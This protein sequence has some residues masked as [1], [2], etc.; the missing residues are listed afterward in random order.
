MF[1]ILILLVVLLIYGVAYVLYGKKLLERRVVKADSKRLTPAYEKFDGVDYVPANKYV[2]YG[3]HFA[4]I[5]GA[6]PIIGPAVAL[7]WGWLL[8]LVWVLFGN[9]FIGAVHDYTAIMASVRHGGVSIMTVSESVMGRRARYIFLAYVWFALVLVLA[10]FL[11]VASSV[12]A[13]VPTAATVA[14][15]YMPLALLFGILVY[16]VGVDVRL[17]TLVSLVLVVAGIVYSFYAPTYLTYEG[18]IVVLALYSIIAAAL[19]VWY[20]L[21]P[22]D[23]L[24]AYL[25]WAFVILAVIAPLLLPVIRFTGPPVITFVAKG[26]VIGAPAGTAA[27]GLDIAW[28]WPTVPLAIACGALSGFHSVVG[29]GTTSKQ[30]ASE[31]DAL[32]VGYGGMLTEGAVSS[33]AVILPAALIWDFAAVAQSAGL[34]ADLLL[35]AGLNVTATPNILRFAGAARFYTAYGFAQALA[36]SRLTG[37][38]LFPQLFAGFKTFAAWALT[39]FVL[40]TLDTS[41]RLARF[42]WV[43]MFDWL[44]PRAPV[45][46][47]VVTN[48]WFASIIPVII[49]AMMAYPTIPGVGRAYLVIWPAFAGT[50]QLLAALAL[51][52]STLWVY[53]IL[54]VRGAPNLLM[55][56]PAMFL[57]ITVTLALIIWLVFIV[58]SLPPLYIAG[59]GTIVTISVILDFLLIALFVRGLKAARGL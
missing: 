31:L 12:Y 2:L 47:K 28:F 24:N 44:K 10:A 11:S 38:E 29:S 41:N 42:A 1:P 13:D 37:V 27:A 56:I 25:L 21:Q 52:T 22:R 34:P 6:G 15:M 58:P 4:S 49:G 14:I 40:T 39:A 36:W 18:W 46:H 20:L 7:A 54:K 51:L 17:A 19:P 23:Y 53:A 5:A 9:I 3:H 32:F 50:N 48:R 43:E 45:V 26:A 35:K 16:K 33:L 30:L 59:T 57:W 8:P 55:L